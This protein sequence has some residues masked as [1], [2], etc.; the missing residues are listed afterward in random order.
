[1]KLRLMPV[2]LTSLLSATLLFGGWFL[3]RQFVIQEPLQKIVSQ[4]EGV[5]NSH[6]TIN[7]D[8]VTLKLDLQPGTKLRQLVQYVS[9]EGKSVID[10][11]RL[12]L[13]VEQHSNAVLDEY[14]DEAMFSVAEAMESRKY[15]LIPAKLDGLKAQHEKYKNVTATTEID[16]TNVYVAISDGKN[17]KFIILPRQ[18]AAMGVWNNA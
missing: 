6:I 16:D 4:Y 11:R 15:T 13:D 12:K 9:T 14:W 2:L 5:N 10:G 17:S 8:Q 7:H 18:P 3:Y 1:M